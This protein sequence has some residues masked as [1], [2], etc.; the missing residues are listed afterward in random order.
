MGNAGDT[1]MFPDKL[2]TALPQWSLAGTLCC[3]EMS[4]TFG[5]LA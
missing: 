3:H 2:R 1:A 4:K 5:R